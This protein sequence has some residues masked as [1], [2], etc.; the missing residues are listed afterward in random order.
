MPMISMVVL[1]IKAEQYDRESIDSS[2][3]GWRELDWC[4]NFTFEH[5][6]TFR[7]SGSSQFSTTRRTTSSYPRLRPS[8]WEAI[9]T[10]FYRTK[11]H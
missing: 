11:F 8:P 6:E 5:K 7:L 4:G 10:C 1:K 2:R 3:R 9:R